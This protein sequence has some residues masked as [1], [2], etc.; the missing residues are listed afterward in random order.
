MDR[1]TDRNEEEHTGRSHD[2]YG[3]DGYRRRN[4]KD[5]PVDNRRYPV[6]HDEEGYGR[7]AMSGRDYSTSGRYFE[8]DPRE[9]PYGGI[10]SYPDEERRYNV[11]GYGGGRTQSDFYMH[12]PDPAESHMASDFYPGS[13]DTQRE[14]EG[15][16]Y[17]FAPSDD[18]QRG[19]YGREDHN[20][21]WDYYWNY[22][23]R[24][25]HPGRRMP[26]RYRND[27]RGRR[28]NRS[29]PSRRNARVYQETAGYTGRV[30]DRFVD[31]DYVEEYR[32]GQRG[33][34]AGM[35]GEFGGWL[36]TT[37]GPYVGRGPKGYVRSTDRI[38]EEVCERLTQHGYLDAS[39]IEVTVENGEVT[40]TGTVDSREAKRLAEDIID[41]IS[42]VRDIHNRLRIGPAGSEPDAQRTDEQE[43]DQS[44]TRRGRKRTSQQ[45]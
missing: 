9:R 21:D 19:G 30:Q 22:G 26:D 15:G 2:D 32:R 36:T 41:S 20:H 18:Y 34:F 12:A 1:N 23:I 31:E 8:T 43:N 14:G 42:G 35:W 13:S 7:Y 37:E 24:G 17:G 5:N 25:Y 6:D 29:E 28:W 44:G 3:R 38:K 40:L 45:T 10:S 11:A 27:A 33:G 4:R 16:E 39:G